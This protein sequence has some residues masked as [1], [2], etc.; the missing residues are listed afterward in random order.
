MI[1]RIPSQNSGMETPR[2][3]KILAMISAGE[4]LRVAEMMPAGNATATAMIMATTA[5][6][7]V[8]HMLL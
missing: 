1:R 2:K 8:G 4:F 7:N 5:S 3:V 6:S